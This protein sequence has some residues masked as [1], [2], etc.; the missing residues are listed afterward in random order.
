MPPVVTI[1]RATVDD[2]DAMLGH[3]QAGFDT[4]AQFAPGG[5]QP[6]A[7]QDDRLRARQLLDDPETWALLALVDG[8]SVGHVAFLPARDWP[9]S[10]RRGD[11]EE[12]PLICGMAHL[13]QLFVVP[14]WWGGGIAPFLHDRAIAEMRSRRFVQARLFTPS[15]HARARRFYERHGWSS[16]GE[17]WNQGLELML[18]QY[19]RRLA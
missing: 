8:V 1:R 12:Y 15:L 5:W 3:V 19:R 4:Y 14:Q 11:P 16:A 18:C 9:P 13:W 6:P 7:A 2:V 17:H 10:G